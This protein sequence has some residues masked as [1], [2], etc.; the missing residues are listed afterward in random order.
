MLKLQGYNGLKRKKQRFFVWF[1]V[2]TDLCLILPLCYI[3][4]EKELTTIQKKHIIIC[5][6]NSKRNDI[7]AL[8]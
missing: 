8:L 5:T 3:L 6:T 1:A 2:G 7:C 4:W